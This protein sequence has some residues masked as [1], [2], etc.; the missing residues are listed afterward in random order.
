[1]ALPVEAPAPIPPEV[2]D[3]VPATMA[4]TPP[5]PMIPEFSDK[6]MKQ[7][8]DHARAEGER[9]KSFQ[10]IRKELEA[11]TR[12]E[13]A[14]KKKA[15]T[16]K[17]EVAAAKKVAA[18]EKDPVKQVVAKKRVVAAEKKVSAATKAVVAAVNTKKVT[19]EKVNAVKAKLPPEQKKQATAIQRG[20]F[21]PDEIKAIDRDIGRIS[22]PPA[23][24]PQDLESMADVIPETVAAMPPPALPPVMPPPPMPVA[25]PV[26]PPPPAMPPEM[27]PPPPDIGLVAPDIGLEDMHSFI[28]A[29]MSAVPSSSTRYSP[30][31]TARPTSMARP[32]PVPQIDRT[33]GSGT[34]LDSTDWGAIMTAGQ[35]GGPE[36]DLRP[37]PD[38]P[39]PPAFVEPPTVQ[40]IAPVVEP[41][42]IV[43][44]EPTETVAPVEQAAPPPIF[45]PGT[46]DPFNMP[47]TAAQF[48]EAGDQ[49]AA[50]LLSRLGQE[51]EVESYLQPR[52]SQSLAE[53]GLLGEAGLLDDETGKMLIWATLFALLN[54]DAPESPLTIQNFIDAFGENVFNELAEMATSVQ[55]SGMPENLMSGQEAAI[56]PG[57]VQMPMQEGGLLPEAVGMPPQAMR[58]APQI[59]GLIPGDGDA[60]ADNIIVTADEGLPQAQDIAVSSG[61]YIVAGDVVSGLGS[62]STDAGADVL[63]QLQDDVRMDRT[64]SPVQPPSI[65]LS[66]VLP[67]TYGERYA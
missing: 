11:R 61:E 66:E 23:A 55:A 41:E 37:T 57:P 28:P 40:P 46:I 47:R 62:G 18:K 59:G 48:A 43:E 19:A 54:P 44:P 21:T 50:G 12:K 32:S 42:S 20:E 22:E 65:D 49:G 14:A 5:L 53:G 56:P 26:A 35:P 16:A 27:G 7:R 15:T 36:E 63:D 17:K 1:M 31:T 33:P 2:A 25:P 64:G 13:A 4:T 10:K 52:T 60:M 39:I 34:V 29:T 6:E 8:E 24:M 51:Q 9:W 3:L 38:A 45:H 67:A 30:P 58:M